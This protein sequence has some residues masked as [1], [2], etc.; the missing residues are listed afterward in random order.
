VV[1]AVVRQ[2]HPGAQVVVVLVNGTDDLQI[3]DADPA[4]AGEAAGNSP[5]AYWLTAGSPAIDAGTNEAD[6]RI[7]KDASGA[8]RIVNGVVDLG[9][10]EFRG[11]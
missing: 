8:P 11:N 3:P 9:A 4:F 1:L 6:A 10:F 2:W 7:H 5:R